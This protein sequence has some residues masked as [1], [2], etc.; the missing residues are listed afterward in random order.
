MIVK[1][2]VW[3]FLD[4]FGTTDAK[5]IVADDEGYICFFPLLIALPF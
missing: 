4:A 1:L 2:L 5:I 3:M